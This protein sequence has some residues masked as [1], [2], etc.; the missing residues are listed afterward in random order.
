MSKSRFAR[1]SRVAICV[2]VGLIFHAPSYAQS[3]VTLYGIVSGGIGYVNNEGGKSV[4]T[5]LTGSLQNN[6]WGI[7]GIEDLGGGL[8]A[9]FALDSAF[10]S[11]NGN[12]QF[13]LEFGRQAYVGLSGSQ[14]GRVT[15]GRQFEVSFDYLAEYSMMVAG[16]G[17]GAHIGDNDNI[18]GSVHYNNSIKYR[19]PTVSGVQGEVMYAMSNDSSFANN[20]LFSTGL[21]YEYGPLK[22][23]AAY[24]NL[25]R[26][27][28]VINANG[29]ATVD[30]VGVPF[31]LFHTSPLSSK[32]GVRTQ[33]VF[34]VGGKYKV[35]NVTL[36]AIVTD[37]R[38][39]YLD[40]TS[41]HLTNYDANVGWYAQPDLEL[42]A[43]YTYTAGKYGGY[44]RSPHWNIAQ[45][46]LDYFLSKRTDLALF[47]DYGT[48]HDGQVVMYT[49]AP[50]SVGANQLLL[51]AAYRLKF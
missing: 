19:T 17:L 51:A 20:R 25:D 22:L 38:F 48:T 35:G 36:A 4:V 49:I 39:T 28:T 6:R 45:V 12:A 10:N 21:S 44:E 42:S 43:G 1:T 7:Q 29:A 3:S 32:V 50:S 18:L 41:L 46:G 37:V 15:L 16:T 5:T 14:W 26:P 47:V 8:Q 9:I 30:Y 34:G 11:M 31:V 27:G 13:G 2:A 33:R 24:S 40:N 23:G